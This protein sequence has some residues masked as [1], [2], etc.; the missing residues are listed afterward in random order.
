VVALV[1]YRDGTIID[2]VRK[3]K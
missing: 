2:V 3:V 1:E